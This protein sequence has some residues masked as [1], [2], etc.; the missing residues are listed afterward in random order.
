MRKRA[1]LVAG[2]GGW[3][4]ALPSHMPRSLA[5]R[6]LGVTPG[7]IHQRVARGLPTLEVDG[8][9]LVPTAAL[10][11]RQLLPAVPVAYPLDR[12]QA[13]LSCVESSIS[14]GAGATLQFSAEDLAGVLL[15]LVGRPTA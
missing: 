6:L 14:G 12:V 2:E 13:V 7:A 10:L 8:T 4:S 3:A 1:S 15:A 5:S 11:D 9:V